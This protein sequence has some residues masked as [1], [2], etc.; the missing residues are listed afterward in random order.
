MLTQNY[1]RCPVM[2]VMDRSGEPTLQQLWAPNVLGVFQL[3]RELAPHM[4]QGPCS[5][6]VQI[7]SQRLTGCSAAMALSSHRGVLSEHHC[8]APLCADGHIVNVSSELGL[9]RQLPETA[10]QAITSADTLGELEK[11]S[12]TEADQRQ[13]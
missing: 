11:V 1:Q 2:Q 9:L 3:I 12:Y 5:W 6:G 10:K 7:L 4:K 13:V 8:A